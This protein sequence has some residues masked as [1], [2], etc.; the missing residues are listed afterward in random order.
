MVSKACVVGQ[1]QMKLEELARLPD[2]ELTV[3]V[4]PFW[5]DERGTLTLERAHTKGYT[6][7]VEPIRFN[8]QFHLHYYPTITRV[9]RAVRPQLVHID[10]E[11]YNLA[12]YLILRAARAASAKTLIFTWQ[13]IFRR[14]PPP[15]SWIESYVLRRADFAIAGNRQAVDVL[16][17]KGYNG[18]LAVL[19]QFGVDPDY[20]CL[21]PTTQIHDNPTSPALRIG[22]AGGRLVP[23]KGIDILLRAV[24]GLHGSWDLR[25]L[26]SGPDK[27]RLQTLAHQLGIESRVHFD[28]PIPS[29]AVP[30]YL[31]QLDLVVLPSVTRSNWKEQF[32]RVLIEAMACQ[33]PVIGSNSGEI[34]NVIGDAGLIFP[35]GNIAALRDHIETLQRNPALRLELGSRGRARVLE[36]YTQARIAAETYAT[37]QTILKE[38][39]LD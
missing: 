33:V 16:R 28:S 26:G 31:G 10:E 17:S 15:F 38:E 37:Y 14:Y 32:G 19:P 1:Y 39:H 34:P 7:R 27:R 21:K 6:F 18:K 3:V 36:H 2:M 25:V 9:I 29:M 35:E 23:E 13:N 24:A 8:G 5:R 20:Y 11:P 30:G 12:S 4:P 22:Y